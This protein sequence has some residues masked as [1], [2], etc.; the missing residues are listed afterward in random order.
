MNARVKDGIENIAILDKTHFINTDHASLMDFI[1]L[2]ANLNHT[3]DAIDEVKLIMN[4]SL[5]VNPC[6]FKIAGNGEK[7][8]EIAVNNAI[9]PISNRLTPLEHPS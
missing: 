7:N 4:I 1:N 2:D 6:P 3:I 5:S 9:L 8:V